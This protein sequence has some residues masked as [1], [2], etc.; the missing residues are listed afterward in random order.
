MKALSEF[1]GQ[2]RLIAQLQLSAA[3]AH[4]MN[5]AFPH[6][7]L[8]GPPGLGKTSLSGVIAETM[9]AKLQP[10]NSNVLSTAADVIMLLRSL[11]SGDVLF[12][13]EIHRLKLPVQECLYTAM[14][15]GYF[16]FIAGKGT[17]GAGVVRIMLPKFTLIGAT[18]MAGMVSAPMLDR[19]GIIGQMEYYTVDELTKVVKGAYTRLRIEDCRAIASVGRGTPRVALK[20]AARVDE[21]GGD[22]AMALGMLGIDEHGMN[23]MDRRILRVIRD[24]H[25]G[26]P[27]G[28]DAVSVSVFETAK[29]IED[30]HEPY[31]VR[32]GMLTRTGRGRVVTQKGWEVV[33]SCLV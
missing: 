25:G 13:D 10:V 1:I 15:G 2:E 21:C 12:I 23:D 24:E 9:G 16:D 5:K 18:T 7:L 3:S 11:N 14:E 32:I 17:T 27:V 26:G 19:F 31:L 30:A 20:Y 28:L 4:R 8:T 6:T 22:V 33:K 29:T